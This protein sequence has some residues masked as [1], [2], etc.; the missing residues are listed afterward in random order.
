MV[1][2]TI[3]FEGAS[4]IT[5]ATLVADNVDG[6]YNFQSDSQTYI[7]NRLFPAGYTINQSYLDSA[8]AS[9][10][11]NNIR[12]T[13]NGGRYLVSFFGHGNVPL[14]CAEDVWNTNDVFT[15]TNTR[16]PIVTIF[17]CQNGSFED[18]AKEC[19]AEAFLEGTSNGAVG[20]VAPASESAHVYAVKVADGFFAEFTNRNTRLGDAL[21]A[22]LLKLWQFNPNPYELWSYGILG[23][24]ALVK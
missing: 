17:S 23:D 4:R 2:K 21:N 9:T 14:W 12:N 15:L 16:V 7:Y 24:P 20:V 5:N 8:S 1:N 22:G 3:S 11:R 18:P 10:I 6:S 19:L 13:I